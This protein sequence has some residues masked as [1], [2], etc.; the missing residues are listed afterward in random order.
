VV[1]DNSYID[2]C[3]DPFGM[4]KFSKFLFVFSL[5]PLCRLHLDKLEDSYPDKVGIRRG[6]QNDNLISASLHDTNY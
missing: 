4:T 5:V 2:N 3:K 1:A 6:E